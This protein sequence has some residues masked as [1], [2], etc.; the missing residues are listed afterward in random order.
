MTPRW[1]PLRHAVEY[2]GLSPNTLRKYAD[3]GII[4]ASRTEG[5]HRRFDR[6]SIDEF[7]NRDQVDKL[8][9]RKALR[10]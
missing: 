1:L 5:Q 8:A 2:S 3:E 10:L 4:R 7:Y 6:E 9:I